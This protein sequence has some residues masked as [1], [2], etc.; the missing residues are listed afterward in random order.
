MF[1][2]V[3]PRL[4]LALQSAF[5]AAEGA[6]GGGSPDGQNAQKN[7]AEQFAHL[8]C[9]HD[10]LAADEK[11]CAKVSYDLKWYGPRTARRNFV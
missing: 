7:R 1:N 5:I 11:F 3:T 4:K 8:C 10:L 6:I 9:E 2:D